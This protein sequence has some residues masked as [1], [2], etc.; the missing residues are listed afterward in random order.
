MGCVLLFSS[1]LTRNGYGEIHPLQAK[2]DAGKNIELQPGQVVRLTECL[3]FHKAGQRIETLGAKTAADYAKIVMAD[4]GQGALINA[5]GI[6]GA[7]LSKLILDGNRPGFQSLE[8]KL[9]GEPMLSFGGEGAV[10][11]EIRN[12]IVIDGRCAGGWGAIHVQE[13]GAAIVI[14]DNVVFSAGADIRGN[15]RSPYEKPFGW[16]D[17]ISSASR[18]TK[19]LNNLIIDATD[20]GIMLQGAPGSLVKDNVIVALSREM[21]GGIVLIDPFGYYELDAEKRT[22]DYRGIVVEDNLIVAAGGRIHAGFPMGGS[23]WNAG[24]DGT[25]LLGA[26][27][28]NNHISGG[29]AGYGYVVRGVDNFEIKGNTS[30]ATYSGLGDGLPGKPPDAPMA[31]MYDPQN[32]GNSELQSDFVPMTNSLTAVLRAS[33]SPRDSRNALGYRDQPYPDDE[34]L[35][36]VRMAFVEMLGRDPTDVE[37]RHWKK[38]LQENKTNADTLRRNLMAR[39]EFVQKHGYIDPLNLHEWRNS[40]WLNL[41]KETCSTIQ[42]GGIDWPNAR[43]W[44]ET[45]MKA[46]YE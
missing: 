33:R 44:N 16:G 46:L 40:R 12:C 19:I 11:Q 3:T 8:G 43:A 31:F 39:P 22:Y 24:F 20:D 38:W 32:I 37:S 17:G 10:G 27:V 7:T 28:L 1:L 34:V 42:S 29:A 35:A 6:S 41:L 5:H 45:L 4:G 15:G 18:D 13:G 2:L 30:D 9:T 23:P 21:L 26:R 14:R 25:T 36:V